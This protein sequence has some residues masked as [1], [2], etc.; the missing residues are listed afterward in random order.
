VWNL[1]HL[2]KDV[3]WC[4]RRRVPKESVSGGYQ[5]NLGATLLGE[6]ERLSVLLLRLPPL[7]LLFI[8]SVGPFQLINTKR[9]GTPRKII[10]HRFCEELSSATRTCCRVCDSNLSTVLQ[11]GGVTRNFIALFLNRSVF[12]HKLYVGIIAAK[13]GPT[14]RNNPSDVPFRS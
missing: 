13:I 6:L 9:N 11:S 2:G 12:R 8:R 7:R 4:F 5:T 1:Q 10:M 3:L 14:L